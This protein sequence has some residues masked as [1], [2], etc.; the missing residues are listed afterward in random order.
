MTRG[1]G[2]GR[3]EIEAGGVGVMT[4]NRP[5]ALNA[6]TVAMLQRM[7]DL[8]EQ[9]G[10]NPEVRVLILAAAGEKAFC[11]GGRSQ[12]PRR[13]V[14]GRNRARSPGPVDP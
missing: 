3:F 14:R 13:R 10:S 5:E 6:L 11:V 7:R 12:E 1:R 4:L 9:I 8:L 2:T